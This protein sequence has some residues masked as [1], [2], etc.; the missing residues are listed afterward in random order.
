MPGRMTARRL[1]RRTWGIIAE[2]GVIVEAAP[3]AVALMRYS[4]AGACNLVGCHQM[5]RYSD[6]HS[7]TRVVSN[8]LLCA[9]ITQALLAKIS[10][11]RL[12]HRAPC[13]H[14]TALPV[15]S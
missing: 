14:R 1:A 6:R 11:W 4:A 13:C 5:Q 7:V 12:H 9:L 2:A 3:Q 10:R 15:I 8:A